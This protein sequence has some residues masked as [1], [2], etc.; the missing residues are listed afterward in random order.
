[1]SFIP[2]YGIQRSLKL[3]VNTRDRL[4]RVSLR[5]VE[6]NKKY[7]KYC[8]LMMRIIAQAKDNYDAE[9]IKKYE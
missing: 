8:N 4:H 5:R 1:M 7:K 2:N 6:D 9:V 3:A